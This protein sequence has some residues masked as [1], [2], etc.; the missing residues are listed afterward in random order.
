MVTHTKTE[1]GQENRSS[2]FGGG[3]TQL[4]AWQMEM[5]QAAMLLHF[6]L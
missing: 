2:G 6:L 4:A 1:A 3:W 5:I